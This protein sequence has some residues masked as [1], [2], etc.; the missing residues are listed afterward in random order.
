MLAS[1]FYCVVKR[2][3]Q[4]GLM[5]TYPAGQ[6]GAV[7]VSV[8]LLLK[9]T[10]TGTSLAHIQRPRVTLIMAQFRR[11]AFKGIVHPTNEHAGGANLLVFEWKGGLLKK[12]HKAPL[13]KL[14]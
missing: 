9:R 14:L 11:H 6:S 13:L 4:K 2:Q 7:S 3:E 12:C 5:S 8:S 1:T 10:V